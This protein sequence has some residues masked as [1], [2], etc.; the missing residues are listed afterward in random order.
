MTDFWFNRMAEYWV[1]PLQLDLAEHV[2]RARLQVVQT[3]TF[4]PM[5]YGLAGDPD[6]D[7][8]WS[9]MPLMGIAENF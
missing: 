5:F 4:G 9:G 2:Q 6:V 7:R 3:G 1:M 8:N